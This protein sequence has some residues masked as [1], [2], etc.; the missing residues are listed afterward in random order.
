MG[1]VERM[2][3]PDIDFAQSWLRQLP[4]KR[5]L[6]PTNKA[7]GFTIQ[8][9][10]INILTWEIKIPTWECDLSNKRRSPQ[11]ESHALFMFVTWSN[12]SFPS[13]NR[14]TFLFGVVNRATRRVQCCHPLSWCPNGFYWEQY[15]GI[16]SITQGRYGRYPVWCFFF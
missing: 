2:N 13:C 6:L 8:F 1:I 4:S 14:S 12:C 5:L 10:T 3:A 7:T 11:L 15:C 9:S 16:F